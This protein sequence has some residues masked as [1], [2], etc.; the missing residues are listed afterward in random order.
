MRACKICLKK[1]KKL[2]YDT[3]RMAVCGYCANALNGYREVAQDSYRQAGE[4]LRRGM[5]KRLKKQTQ[6]DQPRWMKSAAQHELANFEASYQAALGPWLNRLAA[7]PDNKS[8]MFKLIRAER[9]GLIHRTRPVSWGYPSKWSEVARKIRELDNYSCVLCGAQDLELHVHHLVYLSN[10]GTHRKQ[11][12][13]TLCRQCHE[14]EHARAFDF[15]ESSDGLVE[16][17]DDT[18]FVESSE[19]LSNGEYHVEKFN[20]EISTTTSSVIDVSSLQAASK[21]IVVKTPT[22]NSGSLGDQGIK[23]INLKQAIVAGESTSAIQARV[24][25]V[26]KIYDLTDDLVIGRLS[27]FS[28]SSVLATLKESIALMNNDAQPNQEDQ[29]NATSNLSGNRAVVFDESLH[30]K[31]EYY[32]RDESPDLFTIFLKKYWLIVIIVAFIICVFIE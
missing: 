31:N 25:E 9:R 13:M 15:G 24:R 21:P 17:K 7:N 1:R 8:K 26:K 20:S 18:Y 12:L 28:D 10:F 22:C 3:E 11:N 19:E 27:G 2:K 32:V 6:I 16:V 29:K 5:F 14:E 4:M 23:L 30:N